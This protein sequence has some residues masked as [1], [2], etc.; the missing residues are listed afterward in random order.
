[1]PGTP[2]HA[3]K[4]TTCT[5]RELLAAYIA[6]RGMRKCTGSSAY[7]RK[8]SSALDVLLVLVCAH[9]GHDV[10]HAAHVSHKQPHLAQAHQLGL[11]LRHVRLCDTAGA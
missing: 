2:A 6:M 10:L 5:Q 8:A 4:Q 9:G 11:H 7:Q 3:P 1:M